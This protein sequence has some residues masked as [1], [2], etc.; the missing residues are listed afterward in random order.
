MTD[1]KF[2]VREGGRKNGT[3]RIIDKR[4]GQAHERTE[5]PLYVSNKRA[6]YEA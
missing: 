5:T 4:Y 1:M 6:G 3:W 2:I